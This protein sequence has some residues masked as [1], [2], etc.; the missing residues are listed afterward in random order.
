MTPIT[1]PQRQAIKRIFQRHRPLQSGET[2]QALARAAGWRFHYD[3]SDGEA[4]WWNVA[5]P[6]ERFPYA[7]DIVQRYQL[8]RP[9]SYRS[10]RRTVQHGYDCLMV[11]VSGV[12]IG[13]ETDGYS[14]T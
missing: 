4:F 12:W 5:Y 14:H 11:Q 2:A 8:D 10:F 1:K 13:I 3:E 9:M 6:H 7:M